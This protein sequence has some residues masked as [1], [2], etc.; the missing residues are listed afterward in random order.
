[1]NTPTTRPDEG[2]SELASRSANGIDI[3]LLWQRRDN[4]AVVV[5]VDQRTG[6]NVVLDVRE[7][8]SALDIFNH[9][10]AYAAHRRNDHHTTLALA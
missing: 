7:E 8:D 5:V 9:P 4:T 10:Y 6:D 1:M 2:I 3:A